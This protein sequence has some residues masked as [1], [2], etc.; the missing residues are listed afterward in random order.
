MVERLNLYLVSWL[1]HG[2]RQILNSFSA[3]CRI[4][5]PLLNVVTPVVYKCR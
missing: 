2:I 3:Y 1:K 5:Y 4:L